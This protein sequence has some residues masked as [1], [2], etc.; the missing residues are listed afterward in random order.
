M[1]M[2]QGSFDELNRDSI[3]ARNSDP[4]TSHA[5][6]AMAPFRRNTQRHKLLAAYGAEREGLTDEEAGIAAEI[7]QG[8]WKRCAELREMLMIVPIGKTRTGSMGA[9]QRVCMVTTRGLATL[10]QFDSE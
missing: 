10:R 2:Q 1:T 7:A 3:P 5:A 9:E 4:A 6:A 8:A